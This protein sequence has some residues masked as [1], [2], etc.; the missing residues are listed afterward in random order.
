M[1]FLRRQYAAHFS[2]VDSPREVF[3]VIGAWS[4][5][6]YPFY[7]L[8]IFG[9]LLIAMVNSANIGRSFAVLAF[10]LISTFIFHVFHKL[11]FIRARSVFLGSANQGFAFFPKVE[12]VYL[13]RGSSNNAADQLGARL[14]K[15]MYRIL[16]IDKSRM[17]LFSPEVNGQEN[18]MEIL[19]VPVSE[20]LGIRTSGRSHFSSVKMERLWIQLIPRISGWFRRKKWAKNT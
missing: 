1:W 11:T 18:M 16:S 10:V 8:F 19:E 15:K 3:F 9:A 6:W 20:I 13:R 5:N 2:D 7:T 4:L 17:I 14:E 12:D